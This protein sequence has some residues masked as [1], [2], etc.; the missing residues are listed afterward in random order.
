MLIHLALTAVLCLSQ[1]GKLAPLTPRA[2]E[3]SPAHLDRVVVLGAS[4]SAGFGLPSQGRRPLHLADLLKVALGENSGVVHGLANTLLYTDPEAHAREQITEALALKPTLVIAV[5]LPFWFGYG[6]HAQPKDRLAALEQGLT[7]LERFDCPV[8]VG[9]FPDV[10]HSLAGKSLLT[11]GNSILH[12]AQIPSKPC[13]DK[14]NVRLRE[15]AASR[16]QTRIWPLNRFVRQVLGSEDIE[17]RGN[18]YAAADKS[19]LLQA[20]LLHPTLTGALLVTTLILDDL[21]LAGWCEEPTVQWNTE[22]LEKILLE[23]AKKGRAEARRE[24]KQERERKR[25]QK[26]DQHEQDHVQGPWSPRRVA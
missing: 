3:P 4:I 13:L 2:E 8:L 5:D 15:W 18:H 22:E 25:K 16:E 11:G 19:R 6:Y 9:D 23:R 24:R 21:V 26:R 10:R 7:A 17:L 1:D 12:A 14:L 20:D